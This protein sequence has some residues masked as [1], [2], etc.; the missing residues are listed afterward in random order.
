MREQIRNYISKNL[1]G[2]GVPF[3]DQEPLFSLGKIDS[4]GHLKLISFLEKEFHV[5]ISMEELNWK[6]FDS[7]D[8]I[9]A[10][11]ERKLGT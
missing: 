7:V 11:V 8:S 1:L 5:S 4:L 6:N 10:L 2:R 9:H 3:T